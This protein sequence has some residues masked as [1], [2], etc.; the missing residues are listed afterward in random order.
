MFCPANLG[1]P[2]RERQDG[3]EIVNGGLPD[4]DPPYPQLANAGLDLDADDFGYQL[5]P[6]EKE[7]GPM[8][9]SEMAFYAEEMIPIQ[10]VV[11]P[12]DKPMSVVPEEYI[13]RLVSMSPFLLVIYV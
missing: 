5:R 13:F 7:Y 12:P 1:T 9:D 11:E 2:D 6:D 3:P 8:D 10:Q 4:G